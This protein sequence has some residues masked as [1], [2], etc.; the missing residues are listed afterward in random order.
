MSTTSDVEEHSKVLFIDA[1]QS[2]ERFP[3]WMIATQ[4]HRDDADLVQMSETDWLPT[5][6]VAY[7]GVR[8]VV[9]FANERPITSLQEEAIRDWVQFGG[10]LIVVGTPNFR[11][12]TA[13]SSLIDERFVLSPLDEQVLSLKTES[14]VNVWRALK[15][16]YSIEQQRQ[17][18]QVVEFNTLGQQTSKHIGL[19]EVK[20]V[21]VDE[22]GSVEELWH[23]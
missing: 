17:F 5:D 3:E 9:W 12:R 10:H 7:M 11:V 18:Q 15:S 23:S 13:W 22:P 14:T 2:R 21:L 19:E 4:L 8:T 16:S 1:P 20:S 6:F